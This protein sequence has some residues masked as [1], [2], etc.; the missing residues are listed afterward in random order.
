MTLWLAGFSLIEIMISVVIFSA[1]ILILAGLSLQLAKRSTRST[2]Q[3]LAMSVLLARVDQATTI[4]YDSLSTISAC[5]TTASGT[6]S[7]FSCT[8][9]TSAGA[10]RSTV[11]II[12]HTSIPTSRPDTVT[13]ERGKSTG[14]VPTR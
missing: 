10:S 12:V 9:V 4:A 11:Q 7:I 1:V 3:A 5:D 2:D 13:F 6:V 14:G 8:T